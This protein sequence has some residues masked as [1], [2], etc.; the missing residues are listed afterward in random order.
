MK[1]CVDRA[2][3]DEAQFGINTG[4]DEPLSIPQWQE[5]PPHRLGMPWDLHL[6]G[7]V[8]ATVLLFV[9]APAQEMPSRRAGM[10]RGLR[11]RHGT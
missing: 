2:V 4:V 9:L 1:S 5:V 11:S 7:G 10:R 3:Q 8:N 6:V